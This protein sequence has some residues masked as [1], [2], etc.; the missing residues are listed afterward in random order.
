MAKNHN[1][2]LIEQLIQFARLI[3]D[4]EVEVKNETLTEIKELLAC[5]KEANRSKKQQQLQNNLTFVTPE[6]FEEVKKYLEIKVPKKFRWLSSAERFAYH[7][8]LMFGGATYGSLGYDESE[9]LIKDQI[10]SRDV[11]I[12]VYGFSGIENIG[13]RQVREAK[14]IGSV[15]KAM[16]GWTGKTYRLKDGPEKGTQVRG[17]VREVKYSVANSH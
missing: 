12:D 5:E 9:L 16:D 14:E 6:T 2:W 15:L 4:D 10:S 7:K 8:A 17:Y 3:P 11:L 1:Q 13:L